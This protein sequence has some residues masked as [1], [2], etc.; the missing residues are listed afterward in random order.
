MNIKVKKEMNL[1]ELIEY[2]KK[3]EIADKVFLN[4]KGKGKVAG[5]IQMIDELITVIRILEGE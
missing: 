1:L 4:K 2:I 3:N 5:R